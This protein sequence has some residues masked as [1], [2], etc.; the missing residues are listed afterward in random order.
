M[1]Q[2]SRLKVTRK[3][4]IRIKHCRVIAVTGIRGAMFTGI[5]LH[6]SNRI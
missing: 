6:R 2:E 4:I 1:P 5:N 3:A